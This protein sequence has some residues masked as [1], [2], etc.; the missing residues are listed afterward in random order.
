MFGKIGKNAIK[1]IYRTNQ[2]HLQKCV[3]GPMDKVW[4]ILSM[5]P[6]VLGSTPLDTTFVRVG[7]L[8]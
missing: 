1:G 7:Q 4:T 5:D 6:V 3:L 2:I 8:G